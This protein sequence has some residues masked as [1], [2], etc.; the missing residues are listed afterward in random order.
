MACSLRTNG[1]SRS[2]APSARHV[3]SSTPAA[4]VTVNLSLWQAG[5]PPALCSSPLWLR[6]VEIVWNYYVSQL[7]VVISLVVA[8][9]TLDARAAR[10]QRRQ[11]LQ[12]LYRYHLAR[13]KMWNLF[14][15]TQ[16]THN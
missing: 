16:D 9:M 3:Y 10:V 1:A 5:L 6:A 13:A 8:V 11:F 4:T 15:V 7:C 2:R 12:F 14:F